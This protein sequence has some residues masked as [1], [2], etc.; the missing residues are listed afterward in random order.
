[1]DR[2]CTGPEC[3]RPRRKLTLCDAHY[4][5][6]RLNGE[7]RPIRAAV[8]G[9]PHAGP[10]HQPG[11]TC[12][13]VCRCRC[14]GCRAGNAKDRQLRKMGRLAYADPTGTRRRLQALT[15]L[16]WTNA[17]IAAVTGI[18]PRHLATLR[19]THRPIN[20]ATAAK[21]AAGYDRLSMKLP[22]DTPATRRNR[23]DAAHRGWL[24]PLCWD[25]AEIDDPAAKPRAT[26]RQEVRRG[27]ADDVAWMAE[28]GESLL[29]IQRRTG[30]SI[31]GIEYALK[32]ADRDD[33]WRRIMRRE[34]A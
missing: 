13:Q 6:W 28:T 25:D 24:P 2:Q 29:G 16:G 15:A 11:R 10:R 4:A 18:C 12:Y 34:S 21:V 32:R 7:L 17:A 19:N 23:T 27:T 20:R 26:G 30:L 33:L 5:Q 22:P 31:S 9:P 3:T 14:D 1:M 8:R